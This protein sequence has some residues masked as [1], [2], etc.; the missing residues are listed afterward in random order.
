MLKLDIYQSVILNKKIER[1][2]LI[3]MIK[4]AIRLKDRKTGKQ[5]IVYIEAISF[6]E[7]KQIAMR[8]Y[9]LAY[10]IQ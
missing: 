9:G 4:H 10:E 3:K 5:T 1:N 2:V 7:A 6:R 8:D